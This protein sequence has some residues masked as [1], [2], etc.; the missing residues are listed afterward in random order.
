LLPKDELE[1]RAVAT[2][3]TVGTGQRRSRRLGDV[4]GVGVRLLAEGED[5]ARPH[6]IDV[7]DAVI[8]AGVDEAVVAGGRDLVESM[9]DELREIHL[10]VSRPDPTA[11][12]ASDLLRAAYEAALADEPSGV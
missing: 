1:Q 4:A 12:L 2:V 8:I 9:M 3:A 6:L 7:D 10:G 11:P 5:L